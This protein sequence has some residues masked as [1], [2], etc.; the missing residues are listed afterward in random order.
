[1]AV[2]EKTDPYERTTAEREIIPQSLK[3]TYNHFEWPK[4]DLHLY[5][6]PAE[7]AHIVCTA[8]NFERSHQGLPYP[9]LSVFAQSL[10]ETQQDHNLSDLIDGMDLDVIW[11]EK[12][13]DLEG[14]TDVAWAV[15]QNQKIMASVDLG[16]SQFLLKMHDMPQNKRETWNSLVAGKEARIGP[17]LSKQYFSTRFRARQ[18]QD[19]RLDKSRLDV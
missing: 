3:H 1:V 5:I 15:Q 13:L 8:E 10:L 14:N 17:E 4:S 12:N 6:L 18:S 9:K 11:G 19:P 7:D 16:E 2:I